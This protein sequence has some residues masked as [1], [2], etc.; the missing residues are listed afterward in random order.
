[1]Q[2]I[3]LHRSSRQLLE[4]L[5]VASSRAIEDRNPA[6]MTVTFAVLLVKLSEQADGATRRIVRLTWVLFWLTVILMIIVLPP[7]IQETYRWFYDIAS[8]LQRLYSQIPHF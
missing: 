1:M 2:S 3:D 4:E 5:R 6:H 7:V 8:H